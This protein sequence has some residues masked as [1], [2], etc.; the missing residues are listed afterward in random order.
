MPI[1]TFM[2]KCDRPT[3]NAFAVGLAGPDDLGRVQSSFNGCFN[4]GVTSGSLAL[5]PVVHDLGHRTMFTIA[6]VTALAA[7]AIFARAS[8]AE[9]G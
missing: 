5:G 1:F 6:S 7:L 8:R 4:I 9:P 2:N 3:L